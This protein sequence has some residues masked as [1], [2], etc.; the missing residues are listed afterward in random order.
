MILSSRAKLSTFESDLTPAPVRYP[1]SRLLHS[2]VLH[3]RSYAAVASITTVV[4]CFSYSAFAGITTVN[5][6]V[7]ISISYAAVASIATV[8]IT[9]VISIS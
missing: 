9:V 8:N 5:I 4:I 1:C 6:T 2:M 3:V 7:V